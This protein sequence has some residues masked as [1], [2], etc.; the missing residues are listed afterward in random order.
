MIK[1]KTSLADR[2]A[3]GKP[4]LLAEIAPPAGSDP[5]PLL[6][7]ARLFA[8]KVHA[9]GISD[10]REGACMSSLVAAS[11][12]AA[13]GVEPILHVVTRDRNRVALVSDWLGARALGI[14]NVLCTSGTHQT[15]SRF[16][17]ARNVFDIDSVQLLQTYANLGTN[18]ALVGEER[19]DGE[20]AFCLGAVASPFADPVELQAMRLAKKVAAGARF[21]I[22]QPVFDLERFGQWMEEVK[23][24]GIHQRVA[25]VA[26]IL[27]L[28]GAAKAREYA[29][30]RPS[31]R[32]PQAVLDRVTSAA[33]AGAQRAAAIELAV[34]TIR[35]LSAIKELRGFQVS[36]EWDAA[37]A[38]ETIEKSGLGIHQ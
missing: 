20:G 7:T 9:L 33:D 2:I 11:L 19:L 17:A 6:A 14:D 12:V 32:I 25:I 8:G 21:L 37:A 31:P 4:L 28:T 29:Q 34:E 1:E 5:G 24:R 22:T 13:E 3:S 36:G 30:S 38:A 27:P 15:L 35:K 16:R 10:N 26:G 18:A 23:R